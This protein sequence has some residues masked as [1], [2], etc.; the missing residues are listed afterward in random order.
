MDIEKVTELA[1]SFR[2][3]IE[4]TIFSTHPMNNFP[5]GCCEEAASYLS[6]FLQENGFASEYYCGLHPR[7]EGMNPKRHAWVILEEGIVADITGDQ[8][9]N[10]SEHL[11]Y[12]KP[13]YVGEM[14]EFH[15]LFSICKTRHAGG[16]DCY[17]EG[18]KTQLRKE[19]ERIMENLNP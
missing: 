16:F 6:E 4:D 14:D 13:V 19:Y 8:F 3:A 2:K 9:K 10:D 15:M 18:K 5:S 7:G 11:Y 17:D 1:T 12:D